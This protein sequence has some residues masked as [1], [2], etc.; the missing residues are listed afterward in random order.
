MRLGLRCLVAVVGVVLLSGFAAS[1]V[2]PPVAS[3]EGGS[4]PRSSGTSPKMHLIEGF[5]GTWCTWCSVFDP[6]I[7]RYAQER[8]DVVFLAY[9]GPP[10]SDPF[11]VDTVVNARGTTGGVN[12]PASGNPFYTVRGWPTT[13]FDGGGGTL[14]NDNPLNIVGAYRWSIETYDAI[15]STLSTYGDTTSNIA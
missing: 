13:V 6:A 10:G 4:I 15:S 5:T 14:G 8:S 12:A 1:V 7:S 2:S 11:G 3:S 9:H